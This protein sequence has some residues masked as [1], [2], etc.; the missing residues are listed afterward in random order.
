LAEQTR[1]KPRPRSRKLGSVARKR[2]HRS[3]IFLVDALE[4][5]LQQVSQ[6]RRWR[7]ANR[8]GKQRQWAM[9]HPHRVITNLDGPQFLAFLAGKRI[10]HEV[11]E[12]SQHAGDDGRVLDCCI[13]RGYV[14]QQQSGF[15]M[16]K[17][18]LLHAIVEAAGQDNLAKGLSGAQAFEPPFQAFPRK[19]A[20]QNLVQRLDHATQRLSYGFADRLADNGEQRRS[21]QVGIAFNRN[22][23]HLLDDG[24][25]RGLQGV[26]AP[27]PK[28][29]RF[30]DEL[31]QLLGPEGRVVQATSQAIEF[32]LLR[33]NE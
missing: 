11:L 6:F 20:L 1:L 15:A 31:A 9:L 18:D 10:A 30:G 12:R 16:N 33:P 3:A 23:Q 32:Q 27:R 17:E 5:A 19:T 25:E 29:N 24:L 13:A 22:P 26:I 14:L 2:R 7:A 8:G 4:C 21:E 28:R